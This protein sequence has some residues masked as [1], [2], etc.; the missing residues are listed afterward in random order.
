MIHLRLVFEY[1]QRRVTSRRPRWCQNNWIP[2]ARR[3]TTRLTSWTKW[4]LKRA[5]PSSVWRIEYFWQIHNR[6]ASIEDGP[7][8]ILL[9][10][11]S[12]R[13]RFPQ[14]ECF[15]CLWQFS[16]PTSLSIPGLTTSGWADQME[17]WLLFGEG[18]VT[19]LSPTLDAKGMFRGPQ[20]NVC[21]ARRYCRVWVDDEMTSMDFDD[22]F[23]ICTWW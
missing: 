12:I 8:P 20:I 11:D 4:F 3:W 15:S 1:C 10:V 17:R 14:T 18:N 9:R 6:L 5:P 19:L 21:Y 16:I 2:V 13:R 22:T 7:S 23:R